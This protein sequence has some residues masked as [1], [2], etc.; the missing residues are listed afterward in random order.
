[1]TASNKKTLVV[2]ASENPARYAHKAVSM[3]L[4]YGHEV[5]PLGNR[6]GTIS[7]IA[8][9]KDWPQKKDFHSVTLYIGPARQSDEIIEKIISLNPK[10]VIFNPGTENP[11]F[12]QRLK[13][14]AIEVV[15]DC[16][17]VML[18]GERY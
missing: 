18:Q 1:M 4:D 3:L 6:T 16:T 9:R 17:L 15:Q 5:Y 7:H 2:G 11:A 10:R 13:S 12:Y 8:I 14:A